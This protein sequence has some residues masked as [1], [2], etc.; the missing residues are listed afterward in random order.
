[1]RWSVIVVVALKALRRNAMR[2]ALTA[3]GIIIGVAAVIVMV[4]IGSGAQASIEGQIRSAGSNLIIVSAGSGSFGPVRQGQGAVTTLT[5][6]DAAAIRREIS[7]IRY[8]SPGL[9]MRGQLVASA[10]NWNTQIQ[11]AGADLP[12]IRSWP[13]ELG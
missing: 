6:D 9:N 12:A 8:L 1:M 13:V 11:G 4:A 3:L 5:A 7:G 2:T 10:S